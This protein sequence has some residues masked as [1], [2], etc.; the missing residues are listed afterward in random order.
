M[1]VESHDIAKQ[2][3]QLL[4]AGRSHQ[5][6]TEEDIRALKPTAMQNFLPL[7]QEAYQFKVKADEVSNPAPLVVDRSQATN[8]YDH[9]QLLFSAASKYILCLQKSSQNVFAQ[10][11]AYRFEVISIASDF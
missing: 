6:F 1:N 4:L 8:F 7:F 5:I 2:K 11:N 9:V 3:L 10:H